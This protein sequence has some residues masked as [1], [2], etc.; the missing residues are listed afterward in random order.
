MDLTDHLVKKFKPN[1]LVIVAEAVGLSPTSRWG[2]RKLVD[3]IFAK[4]RKDGVPS[5]GS[6][7]NAGLVN[8]FMYVAELVDKDGNATVDSNAAKVDL[9]TFCDDEG[10]DE[11]PACFGFADDEA[12]ECA[13]CKLYVYCAE[14]RVQNLPPCY[15]VRYDSSGGMCQECMEAPHCKS[16]KK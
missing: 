8:D 16:S 4:V 12:P 13:R 11:L 6:D 5:G 1:E 7:G 2:A 10:I 15:G 9:D 14:D 3:V